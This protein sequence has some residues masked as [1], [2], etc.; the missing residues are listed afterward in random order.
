M[1]PYFILYGQ[2]P[3][4]G[5][6]PAHL[7]KLCLIEAVAE[8]VLQ[9]GTIR[10]NWNMRQGSGLPAASRGTLRASCSAMP[11]FRV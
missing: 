4:F 2:G 3:A 9:A 1:Q 11:R 8:D 5:I 7:T 10:G 6:D